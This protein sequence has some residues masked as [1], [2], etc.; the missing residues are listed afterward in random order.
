MKDEA[1]RQHKE[2]SAE[3]DAAL[4]RVTTNPL[5]ALCAVCRERFSGDELSAIYAGLVPATVET[6]ASN[7]V[8]F[9]LYSL[10]KQ[11][12]LSLQRGSGGGGAGSGGKGGN[13]FGVVASLLVASLAGAGNMLV[14]TPAQV[15]AGCCCS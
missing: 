15:G 10:L 14:T 1:K 11:A 12:T 2:G 5:A 3:A 9:Y 7:V 6:V 8:Y 13:E 4:R